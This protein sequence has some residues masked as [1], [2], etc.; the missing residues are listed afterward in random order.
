MSATHDVESLLRDLATAVNR[1]H[2]RRRRQRLLGGLAAAAVVCTA[3]VALAGSYADWWTGAEPPVNPSQVDR[4]IEENTIGLLTPDGSRKATVARTANAALVAVATKGGGYCLI[5]SLTGRPSIGNSCTSAPESEL[6]T[7]ASPSE[8]RGTRVWILYGRVMD[9]GAASLDLRGVGLAKPVPL[10]R[11]GFF[12]L[13]LP[14]TEWTALDNRHGPVSILDASGR[15][16]RTGCAWLGPAPGRYGSGNRWGMLGDDPDSCDQSVPPPVVI[17]TDHAAKLVEI[18]L[19]HPQGVYQPG[20][21]IAMWRAPTTRG[22]T[23]FFIG[24][25]DVRPTPR[26]GSN[27]AGAGHVRIRHLAVAEP[28]PGRGRQGPRR[29]PLHRARHWPRQAR[30]RDHPRRAR[31]RKRPRGTD[32]FRQRRVPRRAPRRTP[33]WQ[34][35][36]P[37]PRRPLHGGSG[38]TLTATSSR[39]HPCWAPARPRS[40]RL[41]KRATDATLTS[42]RAKGA[43]PAELET[44]YRAR[45]D[46]FVRVATGICR[47]AEG[48]RDA[49]QSAFVAA[50]R[51][52]RSFRGS[53]TLEAW[54]WQIVV[55]EARRNARRVQL[56]SL[57]SEE[58]AAAVNGAADGDPLGVRRW[59]A[60]LPP[61]QREVVFCGTSPTSTTGRSRVSSTSSR[62]RC[63]R[64]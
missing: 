61:R 16:L 63:R 46:S 37:R 20:D 45:F 55:N 52:R 7:Y 48:G 58:S 64:R 8:A 2:R 29:R 1:D 26:G 42:V 21:R 10:E 17:D 14:Q 13:E 43:T 30:K 41:N 3:G 27:P 24:L 9:D 18:T 4:V 39:P 28:D 36:R 6:R 56:V 32:R 23:C 35:I 62:G 15:V 11:G 38:T 40:I 53:G 5:P 19:T 54:V 50:V 33:R 31:V 49:V 12:L 57:E 51:A 34:G 60:M 44:L 59:I 47:D 22:D 25:A